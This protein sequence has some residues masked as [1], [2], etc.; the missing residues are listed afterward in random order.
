MLRFSRIVFGISVAASLLVLI[1]PFWIDSYISLAFQ[2]VVVAGIALVYYQFF[3]THHTADTLL[4]VLMVGFTAIVVAFGHDML[5]ANGL[6]RSSYWQSYGF[7]LYAIAQAVYFG[8]RYKTLNEQ[9]QSLSDSLTEYGLISRKKEEFEQKLLR[10]LAVLEKRNDQQNTD[11]VKDVIR[12]L[13]QKPSMP[14]GHRVTLDNMEQI[15]SD[16]VARLKKRF[17]DLTPTEQ[18]LCICLKAKLSNRDIA[19]LRNISP[20]SVKKA[21]GRLRKKIAIDTS[22][23]LADVLATI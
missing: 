19:N 8:F 12:Q 14:V 13:H 16:F 4:T 7:A 21:K 18:E 3:R 2:L 23:E 22:K 15:N 9:V 5:V 6:L 20:D 10:K 11:T 1:T 17:P